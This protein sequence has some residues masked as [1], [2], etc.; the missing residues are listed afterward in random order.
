MPPC[1]CIFFHWN[2]RACFPPCCL[3]GLLKFHRHLGIPYMPWKPITHLQTDTNSGLDSQ[4]HFPMINQD[5]FCRENWARSFRGGTF[6]L[7]MLSQYIYTC[8]CFNPDCFSSENDYRKKTKSADYYG[9]WTQKE[10]DP[11]S[12]ILGFT[13]WVVSPKIHVQIE[14]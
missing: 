12:I 4:K 5:L 7:K 1:V 9:I 3:H 8:S 6:L 10:H 2:S 11:I 14:I 13:H